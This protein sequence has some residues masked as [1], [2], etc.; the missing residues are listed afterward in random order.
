MGKSMKPGSY[1][2][3][4]SDPVGHQVIID[5]CTGRVEYAKKDSRHLPL[6]VRRIP[7]D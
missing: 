1:W 3:S 5:I 6:F 7:L 2:T 4:D